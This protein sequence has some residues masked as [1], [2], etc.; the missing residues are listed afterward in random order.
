LCVRESDSFHI[1]IYADAFV[2]KHL[3]NQEL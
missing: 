2:Y 1:N 3:K